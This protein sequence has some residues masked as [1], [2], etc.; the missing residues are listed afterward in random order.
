MKIKSSIMNHSILEHDIRCFMY[1][2][3]LK[4]SGVI[5]DDKY[6]GMLTS[7]SRK[8][9]HCKINNKWYIDI[10]MCVILE[11]ICEYSIVFEIDFEILIKHVNN[12]ISKKRN[13]CI[14]YIFNNIMK[15][16]LS[17]YRYT[18]DINV[19]TIFD[20]KISLKTVDVVNTSE[21]C[22]ED[23]SG[24][25]TL[26]KENQFKYYYLG[27]NIDKLNGVVTESL[28]SYKEDNSLNIGYAT[29]YIID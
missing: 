5:S 10:S 27:N 6:S 2:V 21:Y 22:C 20:L 29:E 24:D 23:C 13:Y 19:L 8:P 26:Y 28:R 15:P 18:H 14:D 7:L 1:I 12:L 11:N 4:E 3:F 17:T 9:Y 16:V 25:F